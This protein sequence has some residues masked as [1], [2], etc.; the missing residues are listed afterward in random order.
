MNTAADKSRVAPETAK[1]KESA[2]LRKRIQKLR[3]EKGLSQRDFG[4][5]LGGGGTYGH[6]VEEGMKK[7]N[8]KSLARIA[9]ALGVTV[10]EIKRTTT[11]GAATTVTFHA[12]PGTAPSAPVDSLDLRGWISCREAQRRLKCSS[13]TLTRFVKKGQL[14][15]RAGE[16]GRNGLYHLV[17]VEKLVREKGAVHVAEASHTSSWVPDADTDAEEAPL[18]RAAVVKRRPKRQ[19]WSFHDV[20]M[21]YEVYDA[22]LITTE[23]L[24]AKVRKIVSDISMTAT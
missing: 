13:S 12:T 4:L 11:N 15:R 6:Y 23:E 7:F 24:V 20:R 19:T 22:G 1:A 2:I 18:L 21:L 17:D 9:K 16:N 10:S 8:E 14:T 3:E 5:K